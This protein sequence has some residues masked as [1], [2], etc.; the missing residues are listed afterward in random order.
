MQVNNFITNCSEAPLKVTYDE[1]NNS[2]VVACIT[3]L[4]SQCISLSWLS[5]ANTGWAILS[6]P[7]TVT[8]AILVSASDGCCHSLML[9]SYPGAAIPQCQPL[10]LVF[11]FCDASLWLFLC[12][13]TTSAFVA[14]QLSADTIVALQIVDDGSCATEAVEDSF[15]RLWCHVLHHIDKVVVESLK[16][17]SK[18]SSYVHLQKTRTINYKYKSPITPFSQIYWKCY[19]P[20]LSSFLVLGMVDE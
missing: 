19:L 8:P 5:S 15:L 11:P 18:A 1:I 17:R 6:Q 20:I 14:Q 2:H 16:W 7:S 10:I 13:S 4:A 9:A 3:T 12:H